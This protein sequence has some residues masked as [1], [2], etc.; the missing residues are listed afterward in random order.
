MWK[1]DV[2]LHGWK[3]PGS[4]TDDPNC[5]QIYNFLFYLNSASIAFYKVKK[6]L[7][8]SHSLDLLFLLNFKADKYFYL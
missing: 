1:I 8:N 3:V 2:I 6:S 4:T 7:K 5:K